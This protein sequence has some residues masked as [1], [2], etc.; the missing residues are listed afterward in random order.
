MEALNVWRIPLLFLV[1]GL[2]LSFASKFRSPVQLV[3]ERAHRILLPA[4]FGCF[5]LVPMHIALYLKAM[6]YPLKYY[7]DLGHLWFLFNIFVYVLLCVLPLYKLKSLSTWRHPGWLYL[8]PLLFVIETALISPTHFGTF[9]GNVHGFA[10]G[11]ICFCVG[12]ALAQAENR[13]WEYLQKRTLLH[14][15]IALGLY[16]VRLLIYELEPPLILVALESSF[17]LFAVLGA[18]YGWLNKPSKMLSKLS[19][20]VYPMYMVHMVFLYGSCFLILPLQLPAPI[21]LTLLFLTT[22]SL[23]YGFYQF[24]LHIPIVRQCF[25][26]K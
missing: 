21:S 10:L 11:L 2:G 12:I 15:A 8:L 16:L 3:K 24:I 20:S 7:S 5:F 26:M 13:L 4:V 6:S 19:A 23:S 9:A 17:W 25:G 14:G 1:A 22:T 18:A